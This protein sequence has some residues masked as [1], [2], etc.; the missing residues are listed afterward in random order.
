MLKIDRHILQSPLRVSSLLLAPVMLL[1]ALYSVLVLALNS[2][3]GGRAIVQLVERAVAGG[4]VLERL[5]LPPDLQRIHLYGATVTDDRGVPVVEVGELACDIEWAPLLAGRFVFDRCHGGN[6]RVLVQEDFEQ[7]VS[8]TRAFSGSWRNRRR[9]ARPPR[10]L[11]Q[12]IDLRNMDVLV[13]VTDMTLYFGSVW[14]RGEFGMD[15]TSMRVDADADIGHGRILLSERIFSLGPGKHSAE[16]ALWEIER[17]TQPW[18]NARN[19]LPTTATGRPAALDIPFGASRIDGFV[20]DGGPFLVDRLLLDGR[21]LDLD[22]SGVLGLIPERPKVARSERAAIRYAGSATL[23]MAP[24][25][26]VVSYFLPGLITA[27]P[28][29][30]LAPL[31]FD[32]FGTVRFYDGQTTRVQLRDVLLLGWPIDEADVAI[33]LHNG[34]ARL[35]PES[36]ILA[37]GGEVTGQGWMVPR[38]GEWALDLCADGLRADAL[39]AP[40]AD[41]QAPAIA[42]WL[43][44]SLRTSP[45]TC[46]ANAEEAGL[47]LF[48]DLTRKALEVAPAFTTPAWA[49]IQAPMLQ[50]DVTALALTWDAAPF[51][52]PTAALLVDVH[53]RLTHRGVVELRDPE[54]RPGLR[55][56]AQSDEFTL[57]G[58]IDTVNGV[59]P[60]LQ[61]RGNVDDLGRWLRPFDVPAVP[62]RAAARIAFPLSGPLGNPSVGEIE[63]SIDHPQRDPLF[64]DFVL[65][66]RA[67]VADGRLRV[68]NLDVS[69]SLGTVSARGALGLFG[70]SI[71]DFRPNPSLQFDVDIPSLR[72]GRL[73]PGFGNAAQASASFQVGGSARA[74]VVQADAVRLSDLTL[75]GET[76]D[77]VEASSVTLSNDGIRIDDV[78]IGKADGEITGWLHWDRAASLLEARARG[79]GLNLA[80]FAILDATGAAFR[81]DVEFDARIRRPREGAEGTRVSGALIVQ[82][83]EISRY[84]AG[85]VTLVFDTDLPTGVVHVSGNAGADFQVSA[86]VP[87][88]GEPSTMD[89]TFD[90]LSLVDWWAAAQNVVQHSDLAGTLHVDLDPFG[91][92]GYRAELQVDRTDLRIDERQFR[93]VRPLRARW[94]ALPRE[95]GSL[96]Q[97]VTLDDVALGFDDRVLEG[98]AEL[99][100]SVEEPTVDVTL[101]GDLDFSLLRFLPTLVVDAEGL[102][103]IEL[104]AE[105]PLRQPRIDGRIDY[106]ISSVAPRGLGASI[107]LEPGRFDIQTDRI[108]F[109]RE[110]PLRGTVFGGDLEA[111]GFIGLSGLLPTSVDMSAFAANVGYRV[112]EVVNLTLGGNV[113]FV[114]LDLND[115]DTWS[116][117]GDIDLLDGRFYQNFDLLSGYFA[118]GNLGRN[119]EAFAL[120]VWRTVEALRRMRADLSITGRDR[121]FV[122]SRIAN[123]EMNLEMRTD[124]EIGGTFGNMDVRG[125]LET[126]P[127]SRVVY[128]GR[129]F[130]ARTMIL[131]FEGDLDEFGYP[132]PRLDAELASSI[133][134]CVRRER[135]SFSA[136]DPN[137]RNQASATTT[138]SVLITAFV[139]GLL[140]YELTFRLESTPFYDQRDQLSLILTGC[141]VDE[142]TAAQAGAPTLDIVLRPVID[143]VERNV[144]ER[145]EFDDVD[146]IPT[147][148]GSA[149]ILIQDEVSERFS[150]TLDATVGSGEDN[151]QVVRGSY[152]LFD[153][154]IIEVQE[155]SNRQENIRVDTGL[156]FLVVFD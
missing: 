94:S 146:L 15:R 5:E 118:F 135:D 11:F 46:T 152:K 59:T 138:S 153:W 39:V 19:P 54:G 139:E 45:A 50:G 48:G 128:R 121:L 91:S 99:D 9:G 123:A 77:L 89:V 40:F 93:A 100:L 106:G 25:S 78:R 72:L 134:P 63:L 67:G 98:R 47:H 110:T 49:E 87:L 129:S 85:D 8:L 96:A 30:T 57:T 55:V 81:G 75:A 23:A 66:A 142:L 51:P 12:G 82:D 4:F 140:P 130:E 102:A 86:R 17:R 127:G 149:G 71:F 36:R 44:M 52:L 35:L 28:G 150:W 108:V 117:S 2:Q 136:T 41:V 62:E 112:P 73:L 125:E 97:T 10:L 79:V 84:D 141:T 64:P 58:D 7:Y 42:P 104:R 60:R 156:R 155:Q 92:T 109:P 6:G 124:L 119:M 122:D 114:A 43:Q 53:A 147:T 61:V 14:A 16:Q 26:S 137:A 76:I 24:D 31:T 101:Q 133:R 20:W 154:L 13:Q 105:G 90:H 120:P 83:L 148:Q 126:L 27:S 33:E 69:S 21:E 32:G 95:D 131:R 29:A 34:R 151:R 37:W 103:Q 143:L 115:F 111:W 56:R 18:R 1:V 80:D 132:M 88:S 74:P 70:A 68:Q 3:M 107:Y 113:R 38:T 22:A 144:E 145:L 65:R 116:L